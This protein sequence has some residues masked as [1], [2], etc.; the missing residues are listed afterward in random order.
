[1][2]F[3]DQLQDSMALLHTRPELA[4]DHIL[5]AAARQFAEGDVQHWWLPE[6]G[7]GIR[8][9]ISDDTAWLAY[10]VEHYVKTTGDLAILDEAIPFIEGQSLMPGEHDVFFLPTTSEQEVS[11]YEH[12]ARGLDIRLNAGEHGLPLIGTGDWNDGMNRVGEAGKGESVW[13]GW[14]LFKVLEEFEQRAAQRGDNKRVERWSEYRKQLQLSL[15][16]NAWDGRWYRRAYFDDGSPLGSAENEE[17]RIDAIA[18]SWSVLSGAA[19]ADKSAM[20][21]SMAYQELVKPEE[22]LALLFTPPFDQTKRDPGYIKAYPP[23]IR[24]NGG[25]YTHGV[26]WSIFAHAAL[27][28]AAE[29]GQ[30][31]SMINPINHALTAKAVQTYKV[32][33]YVI[34]AD[35]YSIAPHVGRGGWTWYTGSA[36]WFYRA[37]LEA[38]LGITRQGDDCTS[39]HVCHRIGMTP[40]LACGTKRGRCEIHFLRGPDPSADMHAAM[41]LVGP[42]H[43]VIALSKLPQDC[44]LTLHLAAPVVPFEKPSVS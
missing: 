27:G 42:N 37:G 17:C 8:T 10:C 41:T 5:R 2:A 15:N 22:G 7:R 6:T 14:F 19:T 13:L 35:V 34:A 21:L 3:R 1:M 31:F 24:E 4:R 44:V 33:P 39:G 29:A 11:L 30:L 38:I 16:K 36:G 26:I 25:Q 32:E 28:Q 43:F 40:R 9:R 18:Q 20:A 23:G 12:C